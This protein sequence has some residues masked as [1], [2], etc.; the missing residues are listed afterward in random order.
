MYLVNELVKYFGGVG[1]WVFC[2]SYRW[3]EE[4]VEK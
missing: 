3:K 2:W 1:R 4:N